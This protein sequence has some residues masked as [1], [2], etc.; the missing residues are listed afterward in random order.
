M[1]LPMKHL[2][3]ALALL[4]VAIGRGQCAEEEGPVRFAIIGLSHDHAG[5]FI[6]RARNRQDIQLVGIVESNRD[7]VTRYADRFKLSNDLFFGSLDEL[8]ART[9]IQAVATFTSTFE[10]RRV[11]EAC[12]PR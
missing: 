11:V 4:V 2:K 6:P 12:A 7:L 1:V 10:H 9:N 5:G 8:L 3:V